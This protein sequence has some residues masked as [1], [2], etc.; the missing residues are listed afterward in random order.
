MTAERTLRPAR[1]WLEEVE[2]AGLDGGA[3]LEAS[4]AVVG[5]VE[6]AGLDCRLHLQARGLRRRGHGRLLPVSA[7]VFCVNA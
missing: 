5:G 2:T 4:A 3:D 1:L 6:T 7:R